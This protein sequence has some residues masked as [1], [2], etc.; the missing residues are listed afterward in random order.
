MLNKIDLI[1]K[2]EV[3]KIKVD[4]LKK[5]KVKLTTLSTLDKKSISKIKSEIIK[6]V[7]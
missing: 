3:E 6:Y 1:E 7:S 5:H 2:K 4:F